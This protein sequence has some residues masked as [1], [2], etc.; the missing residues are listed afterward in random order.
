MRKIYAIRD[1]I[2]NDLAGTFP[3]AC[4]N[5]DAQAVRYFG[6]SIAQEK[7]A[8]GAHPN[9]YELIKCGELTD[10]GKIAA[11]DNPEIVITGTA[12]LAMITP[13]QNSQLELIKEAK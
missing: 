2:A 8:L 1:R 5:T 13:Q 7:S 11:Y 4:F 9:D 10:S 12:I 3:L 6:D